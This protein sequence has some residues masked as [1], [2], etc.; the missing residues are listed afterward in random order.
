MNAFETGMKSD[1]VPK[2]NL[3]SNQRTNRANNKKKIIAKKEKKDFA[4]F[5]SRVDNIAEQNNNI[6]GSLVEEEPPKEIN[7]ATKKSLLEQYKVF[8]NSELKTDSVSKVKRGSRLTNK[9]A[10]DTFNIT[11]QKANEGELKDIMMLIKN[12]KNDNDR[13]KDRNKKIVKTTEELGQNHQT[14][15]EITSKIENVVS[16]NN[17]N[18][19]AEDKEKNNLEPKTVFSIDMEKESHNNKANVAVKEDDN[20]K[21]NSQE[22]CVKTYNFKK[23]KTSNDD[24]SA[25]IKPNTTEK[26]K[27]SLD[28]EIKP[29][30]MEPEINETHQ[31]L[32]STHFAEKNGNRTIKTHVKRTRDTKTIS[33]NRHENSSMGEKKNIQTES[34][35]KSDIA[36]KHGFINKSHKSKHISNDEVDNNVNRRN[37]DKLE[38]SQI[39]A[40]TLNDNKEKNKNYDKDVENK[41]EDISLQNNL[42]ENTPNNEDRNVITHKITTTKNYTEEDHTESN[43]KTQNINISDENVK[44]QRKVLLLEYEYVEMDKSNDNINDFKVKDDPINQNMT[45][46]YVS[47]DLKDHNVKGSNISYLENIKKEQINLLGEE[48][49]NENKASISNNN[50]IKNTGYNY[51]DEYRET[52]P[53]K[54]D[55]TPIEKSELLQLDDKKENLNVAYSSREDHNKNIHCLDEIKNS[56]FM[57]EEDYM[58]GPKEELLYIDQRENTALD[59]I[60]VDLDVEKAS[61]GDDSDALI[62]DKVNPKTLNKIPVN[63][64]DNAL[65]TNKVSE[66]KSYIKNKALESYIKANKWIEDEKS[67]FE[68]LIKDKTESQIETNSEDKP[69]EILQEQQTTDRINVKED[70]VEISSD[71]DNKEGEHDAIYIEY[72]KRPPCIKDKSFFRTQVYGVDNSENSVKSARNPVHQFRTQA[73]DDYKNYLKE[74]D[75]EPFLKTENK[76]LV[77]ISSVTRNEVA[78]DDVIDVDNNQIK[79]S[80]KENKEDE[81]KIISKSTIL[82]ENKMI[83]PEKQ[84]V[85]HKSKITNITQSKL[86]FSQMEGFKNDNSEDKDGSRRALEMDADDKNNINVNTTA[87]EKDKSISSSSYREARDKRKLNKSL[88]TDRQEHLNKDID[89]NPEEFKNSE[90]KSKDFNNEEQRENKSRVSS[91]E[92][93]VHAKRSSRNSVLSSDKYKSKHSINREMKNDPIIFVDNNDAKKSAPELRDKQ[94]MSN[95]SQVNHRTVHRNE[96]SYV[97]ALRENSQV[98]KRNKEIAGQH[99][100]IINNKVF[101]P[102]ERSPLDKKNAFPD[103]TKSDIHLEIPQNTS[104]ILDSFKTDGNPNND[105]ME[106]FENNVENEMIRNDRNITFACKGALNKK[107][108]TGENNEIPTNDIR[109]RNF[110][111]NQPLFKV[112]DKECNKDKN[113]EKRLSSYALENNITVNTSQ[114]RELNTEDEKQSPEFAENLPTDINQNLRKKKDS[115][116]NESGI[117]K[118]D[119]SKEKN[120]DLPMEDNNNNLKLTDPQN[121]NKR[122]SVQQNIEID[123][124]GILPL[125]NDKQNQRNKSEEPARNKIDS[126]KRANSLKLKANSNAIRD[127]DFDYIEKI[128]NI[129]NIIDTK[130]N[131]VNTTSDKNKNQ[132]LASAKEEANSDQ[133]SKRNIIEVISKYKSSMKSEDVSLKSVQNSVNL[134]LN[135]VKLYDKKSTKSLNEIKSREEQTF[136]IYQYRSFKNSASNRSIGIQSAKEEEKQAALPVKEE[137]QA[138]LPVKEEKLAALPVKEEKQAALPVKEEKQAALPVKEEKQSALPVKEEKQSALPVKEEKQVALPVKEEKIDEIPVEKEVQDKKVRDI[139]IKEIV[140]EPERKKSIVIARSKRDILTQTSPKQVKV[141]SSDELNLEF[142][143]FLLKNDAE[144]LDNQ[145][146]MLKNNI[147]RIKNINRN[148]LRENTDLKNEVEETRNSNTEIE[149]RFNLLKKSTEVKE[150]RNIKSK[151]KNDFYTKR[152]ERLEK[153]VFDGRKNVGSIFQRIVNL[154]IEHTKI[155]INELDELEHLRNIYNMGNDRRKSYNIIRASETVPKEY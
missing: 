76:E 133:N 30:D 34:K 18:D 119:R 24:V 110:T 102:L 97:S 130:D 109:D 37:S 51:N 95:I 40:L 111:F 125:E 68:S 25:Q 152:L 115:E 26:M 69:N 33:L 145:T 139:E 124:T 45:K 9:L 121:N 106:N 82:F 142:K 55:I 67:P 151:T 41:A 29:N 73:M 66:Y 117:F 120:P 84:R 90:K 154:N 22:Y 43:K 135:N 105:V 80:D 74:L 93:D 58:S 155:R 59:K 6:L 146:L 85:G 131:P 132:K 65:Y 47:V 35:N 114:K 107:E 11:Y 147:N 54:E 98:N 70:I 56:D 113:I 78:K 92:N 79:E 126:T 127:D 75:I 118:D 44:E 10:H 153:E 63:S 42:T 61:K 7:K 28:E 14:H 88:R 50:D 38:S 99:K 31:T 96:G 94:F 46:D 62:L 1:A 89:K 103:K 87:K 21:D 15:K 5:N 48:N 141:N 140:D 12:N 86:D 53:V 104:L 91:Q 143:E 123:K 23:N 83:T 19:N 112:Q 36:F 129:E 4:Q 20:G 122:Y 108:P 27:S 81:R 32:E 144:A 8:E 72:I 2:K 49:I 60:N 13:G 100:R 134:S 17:F 3:G 150:A 136:Q 71:S 148:L 138:A 128:S 116:Y 52:K 101:A 39:N 64:G 77:K 137:K 16:C 149:T 57:K